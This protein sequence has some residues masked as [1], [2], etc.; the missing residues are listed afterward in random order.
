MSYQA[1]NEAIARLV[2]DEMLREMTGRNYDRLFAS[3]RV[4]NIVDG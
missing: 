2:R 4:L 3:N 1:A